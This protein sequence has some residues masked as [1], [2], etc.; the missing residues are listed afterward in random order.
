MDNNEMCR[1]NFGK[2]FAA[3]GVGV[4]AIGTDALAGV[5]KVSNPAKYKLQLLVRHTLKSKLS[6]A[7]LK[8]YT[9]DV[10]VVTRW[11][12]GQNDIDL[13]GA[14]ELGSVQKARKK[15]PRVGP[16]HEYI[17]VV[18]FASQQAFERLGRLGDAPDPAKK[19]QEKLVAEANKRLHNGA[20][21]ANASSTSKGKK[22][23]DLA[24]GKQ[25][26]KHLSTEWVWV[27]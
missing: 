9:D 11:I 21:S 16:P 12:G 7:Q 27:T 6:S 13:L 25:Y 20:F 2:A 19:A 1:R 22:A 3:A 26:Y 15:Q 8:E 18:G 24:P 23:R 5:K 10:D 4:A 17:Y 14:F